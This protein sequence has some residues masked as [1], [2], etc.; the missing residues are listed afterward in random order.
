MV[1]KSAA[2]PVGSGAK[3]EADH[4]ASSAAPESQSREETAPAVTEETLHFAPGKWRPVSGCQSTSQNDDITRED[5]HGH[6]KADKQRGSRPYPGCHHVPAPGRHVS[7]SAR[8]IRKVR[9]H[10]AGHFNTCDRGRD[11]FGEGSDLDVG[12]VECV[13]SGGM[14]GLAGFALDREAAA[15]AQSGYA[16]AGGVAQEVIANI[17]TV[18]FV[19]RNGK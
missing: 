17:W 2:D 3:E 19:G 4:T 1:Y 18:A 13:A 11:C 15:Q 7:D 9:K 8:H 16:K 12:D 6:K 5:D 10:C 14:C